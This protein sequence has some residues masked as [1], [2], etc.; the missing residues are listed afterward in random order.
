MEKRSSGVLLHITS[1]P[2][3]YGI[4]DFGPEAYRFADFLGRA[5]QRYWQILPLSPPE[6]CSP[7]SP[8]NGLSAF[9]VNI[10]LISP[11]ELY[12]Q[13][14]LSKKEIQD[15]PKLPVGRVEYRSAVSYKM[16]LLD[17]AFERFRAGP[18]NAD[19]ARFCSKNTS[20]LDDFVMFVALRT[21]FGGRSWCEWPTQLRDRNRRALKSITAQLSTA[22]ERERFLQY[23]SSKQWLSLKRYC[24]QHGIRI[25]GDIPIYVSHDS[26]DVWA[27]PEIFKLTHTKRPRVVSGVPPDCFSRTGQLWGHPIYDWRILRK[28]GYSWWVERIRHNLSLLDIVRLDHFTGFAAY[29]QVPAGHKTARRGRWIKGP[30]HDLFETLFEQFS[31]KRFIAEDLGHTTR[32][33]TALVER[34]QLRGMKLLQLGFDGDAI[35][36]T[37]CPHNHAKHCVAYTG[38][39]DN[40]TTRGWFEKELKPRQ[41]KKLSDYLGRKVSAKQVHSDL[42]RLAMSSVCDLCI[43]PVQDVLGLGE[44]ARMNRPG[45]IEGN[46][47][48]RLK[49]GQI[50]VS[51]AK[52]FAKLTEVYGRA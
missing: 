8:Y 19:Y 16:K 26:S 40:N 9:A 48:W 23:V 46:W 39:H 32:S 33:V 10:S 12:R 24:N 1:L 6:P 50:S 11:D 51:V 5:K 36:N 52:E 18:A 45:T 29:W 49:P 27:H 42:M 14:L 22:M 43:I 38:T 2:S 15:R 37:H 13:G 28:T 31:S 7:Y 21:H 25:I 34:F 4:G 44:R 3:P 47:S 30:G 35:T 41:K 17:S 20:W